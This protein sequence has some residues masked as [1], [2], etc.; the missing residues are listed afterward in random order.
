MDVNEGA[1]ALLDFFFRHTPSDRRLS[2]KDYFPTQVITLH[3]EVQEDPEWDY[4]SGL[5]FF[6]N[7]SL[8]DPIMWRLIRSF[9]GEKSSTALQAVPRFFLRQ[10][11]KWS[12]QGWLKAFMLHLRYQILLAAAYE[13]AS[14]N[15]VSFSFPKSFSW[16]EKDNL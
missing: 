7:I 11:I 14:V 2:S 9:L 5:I 4:G 1:S 6:R 3:R 12:N 15:E 8:A 10:D 16:T 13:G